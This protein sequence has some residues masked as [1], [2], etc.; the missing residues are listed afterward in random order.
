MI[1][2]V[3]VIPQTFTTPMGVCRSYGVIINNVPVRTYNTIEEVT[4][5]IKRR[6]E[7][8]NGC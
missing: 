5:Y 1:T 7:V 2:S 6:L 3:K 8:E 4:A